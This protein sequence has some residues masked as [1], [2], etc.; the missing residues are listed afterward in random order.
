[1]YIKYFHL[2]CIW[3]YEAVQFGG[4]S[5]YVSQLSRS[6]DP[7]SPTLPT[8]GDLYVGALQSRF[9]PL[10]NYLCNVANSVMVS[11]PINRITFNL[12]LEIKPKKKK[13]ADY[14]RQ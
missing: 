13:R 11:R 2:A 7:A 5:R 8:G 10:T 9:L 4:F 3:L 14:R 6:R 1:M 12:F